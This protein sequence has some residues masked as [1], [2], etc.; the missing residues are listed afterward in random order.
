MTLPAESGPSAGTGGGDAPVCVKDYAREE[1]LIT[2][3]DPVFT[4]HRF[5][6]VPVRIVV[7]KE[8]KVKHI[9][10]LSAFPDQSK[11]ISD[12]LSQWKFKPYRKD[13]KTLEVETGILFGNAPSPRKSRAENGATD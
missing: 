13:G 4:T 11:A 12:A 8:G 1:N 6:P 10:F 2:R 7:D 3:V 5:N 9:H